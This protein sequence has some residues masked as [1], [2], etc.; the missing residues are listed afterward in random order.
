ML[1]FAETQLLN[2]QGSEQWAGKPKV[3]ADVSEI[4]YP[5][6]M[7]LRMKVGLYQLPVLCG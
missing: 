1:E 3:Q 2:T 7:Y 6:I 4:N 5:A